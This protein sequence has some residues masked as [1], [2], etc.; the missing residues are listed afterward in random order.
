MRSWS[1]GIIVNLSRSLIGY[2]KIQEISLAEKLTVWRHIGARNFYLSVL[3]LTITI[4]QSQSE[5]LICYCKILYYIESVLCLWYILGGPFVV[6][7]FNSGLTSQGFLKYS[8]SYGVAC[9]TRCTR[10]LSWLYIARNQN[11]NDLSLLVS[12]KGYYISLHYIIRTITHGH[13]DLIHTSSWTQ[14]LAELLLFLKHD[15]NV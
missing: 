8:N 4:S 13:S 9:L 14:S 3:L 15:K 12:L 2:Y 6:L 7:K 11:L 5:K 10:E 1:D